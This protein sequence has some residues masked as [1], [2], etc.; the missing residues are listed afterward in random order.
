[1]ARAVAWLLGCFAFA[2]PALA[3]AEGATIPVR[4][5][6]QGPLGCA[7]PRELLDALQ[8]RNGRARLAAGDEPAVLLQMSVTPAA[9]GLHG[10]LEVQSLDGVRSSRWV[11]GDS[12]QAVI[13]ALSLSA[14]LALQQGAGERASAAPAASPAPSS[15]PA[16][17]SNPEPV[18]DLPGAGSSRARR[19]A[20]LRCEAGA[21]ASL[22]QMVTPHLST[23]GGV[24]GRA[25]LERGPEPSLSLMLSYSQNELFESSRH[26]GMHLTGLAL[27]ACPARLAL[28]SRV[29]V[30]PC[31]IGYGARLQAFGRDLAEAESVTRSWWGVG[32]LM[33]LAL[34][35]L[36]DL[37]IEVEGGA[38]RPLVQ[39]EFVVLPSGTS[40]GKTPELAPFASAGVVYAL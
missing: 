12:C 31:A 19:A 15:L 10:L 28:A 14:A 32:A 9:H 2:L 29:H 6:L 37:A 16:P 22:A 3:R 26:V 38:L 11:D 13:E 24:L 23:G 40:L 27:S 33:R 7:S 4:L 21:Q 36:E 35:P 20:P 5:E 18:A 1:M 34:S 17:A 25:R 8:R 39:R 30:E